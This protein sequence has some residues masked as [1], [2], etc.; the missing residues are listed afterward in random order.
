MKV[1]AL[2]NYDFRLWII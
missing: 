2:N 1:V